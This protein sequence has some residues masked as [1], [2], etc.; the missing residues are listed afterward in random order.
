MGHGPLLG[1]GLLAPGPREWLAGMDA[2]VGIVSPLTCPHEHCG[3][4]RPH[5]HEHHHEHCRHSCPHTS[6]CSGSLLH[7]QWLV[8]HAHAGAHVFTPH[9]TIPFPPSS[10]FGLPTLKYIFVYFKYTKINKNIL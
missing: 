4:L 8:V 3:H 9:K 1:C 7:K 2:C 10:C 5:S 6:E